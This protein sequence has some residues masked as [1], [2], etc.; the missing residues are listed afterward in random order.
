MQTPEAFWVFFLIS[1]TFQAFSFRAE[2]S[3]QDQRSVPR[4]TSLALLCR[5]ND[6]EQKKGLITCSAQNHLAAQA[7]RDGR[8]MSSAQ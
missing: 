1:C 3:V 4:D 8:A 2:Q 6:P 7:Q 5:Y